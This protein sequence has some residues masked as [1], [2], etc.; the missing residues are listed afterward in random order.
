MW[1]KNAPPFGVEE[2]PVVTALSAVYPHSAAV[3]VKKT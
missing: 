1:V 3:F 2:P